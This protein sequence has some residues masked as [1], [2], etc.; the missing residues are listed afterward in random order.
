LPHS[1]RQFARAIVMPN[2]KPP[3]TTPRRRSAYRGR[4][5]AGAAQARAAGEIDDLAAGFEPL[6]TLYLT[7][8]PPA[9]EEIREPKASG[10]VHAV[11]L[12]PAG[13][14]TNSAAGVTDMARVRPALEAMQTVDLPL[15]VHGEVTDPRRRR[16]RPRAGLPRRA[17][18]QPLRRASRRCAWCSSTS[19][20]ATPSSSCAA[21]GRP[22]SPPRSPR[23]TCCYN[24]NALFPAACARTLL[25]A[26]AQARDAP[27]GAGARPPSR[28]AALLPRHRQ[29]PA[30]ARHQ[31]ARLRLRR[32]VTRRTHA[33][34]LY[35]EAFEAAGALDR[36]RASPAEFG[37]RFYGLPVNEGQV[38]LRR[39]AWQIPDSLPFEDEAIVP[40]AAGESLAWQLVAG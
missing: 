6:M 31:G 3:V 14:T 30:S 5:L 20:R 13:A 11:K 17:S 40:L 22:L 16:V 12:Y 25:P 23:T 37:P 32:H 21:G 8:A 7:D 34:E 1:A 26:R 33:I 4:I 18:S 2:L 15:L 9:H 38:T 27:R 29:R 19:P 24:R 10:V 39:T 36:S 28:R 35:A